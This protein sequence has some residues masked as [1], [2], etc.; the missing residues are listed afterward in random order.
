MRDFMRLRGPNVE[1]ESL[2]VT[3]RAVELLAEKSGLEATELKEALQ[4]V[5]G[6]RF[7]CEVSTGMIPL[8]DLL[9]HRFYPSCEW[10]SP[11]T[12]SPESWKLRAKMET[13]IEPGNT[14]KYY[15]GRSSIVG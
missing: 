10:E 1:W 2:S 4:L 7:S 12:A 6:R 8:G 11:S 15:L 3:R 13:W 5:L 14:W 9:N